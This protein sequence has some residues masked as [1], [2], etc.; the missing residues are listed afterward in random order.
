MSP[1]PG[2]L[3]PQ[4]RRRDLERMSEGELDVLVIGGGVTGVGCA[5]D[6]A[7]RGL[8]VGLVEQRDL[9]SGTSS[10]S[11][12]LM[13]GGLRYL[14]QM[15]FALVHEAL[16]ERGLHTTSIA[17]HLVRPISFLIPLEVESGSG[18]TTAP[19]CSSM[20]SWRS[21]VA[22]SFPAIAT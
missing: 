20:T 10:R 2:S 12:K 18:P 16:Q 21:P 9:A 22:R 5:L 19:A 6:A 15:D 1:E 3:N 4:Q 7:T 14:E 17:P 11:S 8:S 13:H